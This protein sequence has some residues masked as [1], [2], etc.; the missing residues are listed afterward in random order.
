MRSFSLGYYSQYEICFSIR[1][2][3]A[4]STVKHDVTAMSG[5]DYGRVG[6]G[7]VTVIADEPR[8]GG[9]R[10]GALGCRTPPTRS[11]RSASTYSLFEAG[12]MML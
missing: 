9:G 7:H 5:V 11:G 10:F 12:H 6:H 3:Q 2:T 4:K 1:T 8:A